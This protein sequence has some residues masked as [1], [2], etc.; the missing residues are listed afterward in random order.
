M[1]AST[2]RLT[3]AHKRRPIGHILVM[4]LNIDNFRGPVPRPLTTG[5]KVPPERSKC[6]VLMRV[7]VRIRLGA[8]LA[9]HVHIWTLQIHILRHGHGER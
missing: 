8:A 1:L 5:G 6:D 9:R 3:A 4:R 2:V 7:Q